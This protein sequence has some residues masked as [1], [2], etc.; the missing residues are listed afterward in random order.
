M[1][2]NGTWVANERATSL[3]VKLVSLVKLAYD[4]HWEDGQFS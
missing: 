3:N 2:E 4:S 1:T